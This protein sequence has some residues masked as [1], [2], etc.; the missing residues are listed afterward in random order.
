MR[1]VV[2]HPALVRPA[3]RA[4]SQRRARHFRWAVRSRWAK[5]RSSRCA[6][7]DRSSSSPA[8]RVQHERTPAGAPRTALRRRVL[9]PLGHAAPHHPNRGGANPPAAKPRRAARSTDRRP[10]EELRVRPRPERLCGDLQ[11]LRLRARLRLLR[12]RHRSAE[13]GRRTARGSAAS[14]KATMPVRARSPASPGRPIRR[15]ASHRS[16][17]VPGRRRSSSIGPA[18]L[19]RASRG[20]LVLGA[21]VA[22]AFAR[23]GAD[24]IEE[25]LGRALPRTGRAA[26]REPRS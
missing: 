24:R 18:D 13:P 19:A 20:K 3:E 9:P 2:P 15:T 17:N 5:R 22:A 8:A 7:P 6:R 25:G 1:R 4:R 11:R 26:R 16:K 21:R 12:A 10:L 23:I 14:A